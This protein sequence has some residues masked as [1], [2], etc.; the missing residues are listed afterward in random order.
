MIISK[1]K[2]RRVFPISSPKDYL[3]KHSFLPLHRATSKN[4]ELNGFLHLLFLKEILP[5]P[6]I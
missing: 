3:L 2:V 4:Q 6:T 1:G 5:I